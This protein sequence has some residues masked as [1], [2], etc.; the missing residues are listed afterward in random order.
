[1]SV[2]IVSSLNE[3]Q[4]ARTVDLLY[5]EINSLVWKHIFNRCLCSYKPSFMEEEQ[6]REHFRDKPELKYAVSSW[7]TKVLIENI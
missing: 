7:G 3:N 5:K 6:Y 4:Y 1:M 2:G